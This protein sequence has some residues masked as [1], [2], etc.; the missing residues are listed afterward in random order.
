M[1]SVKVPIYINKTKISHYLILK[2]N[3]KKFILK[4]IDRNFL[5][6]N[7]LV[8]YFSLLRDTLPVMLNLDNDQNKDQNF[9]NF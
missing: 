1:L 7:H 5:N 2:E 9:I 4:G 6:L 8:T 3:K